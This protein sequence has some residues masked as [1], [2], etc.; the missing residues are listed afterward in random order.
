MFMPNSPRPPSG[1][2][3]SMALPSDVT[4]HGLTRIPAG[5]DLDAAQEPQRLATATPTGRRRLGPPTHSTDVPGGW[6][7]LRTDR[8]DFAETIAQLDARKLKPTR[9]QAPANSASCQR[10][11]P[12]PCRRRPAASAAPSGRRRP[13]AQTRFRAFASVLRRWVKTRCG[14]AASNSAGRVDIGVAGAGTRSRTT[15]EWTFGGGRNAPGGS[16]SSRLDVGAQRRQDASARRS[17]RCPGGASSRSATSRCSISVAS[18]RARPSRTRASSSLNRIG[19]DDVVG[20]VAGDA[21]RATP[22]GG[23]PARPAASGRS[24]RGSRPRRPSAFGGARAREARRPG[25]DR[26]RRRA[27]CR[28]ARPAGSVSAPRPGPISRNGS[29]ALR[30]DRRADHLG[31]PRR[32]EEV[33]AEALARPHDVG[34]HPSVIELGSPRQ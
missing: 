28:R 32:L 29:S 23:A 4:R 6:E 25:R 20:E 21:D 3:S 22:T 5:R 24:R 2:T 17:R 18:R 8:R 31:D 19:D 16:V 12:A 13:A 1:T 11:R 33:L 9:P 34:R 15:A 14:P 27:P 10:L 26:S 30:A 7:R